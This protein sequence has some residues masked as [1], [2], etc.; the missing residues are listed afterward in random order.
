MW[1]KILKEQI[2]RSEFG[3]TNKQT[4]KALWTERR[5]SGRAASSSLL[6]A[7]PDHPAPKC[8][9][10]VFLAFPLRFSG[11]YQAVLK[12]NGPSSL[13]FSFFPP[14]PPHLCGLFLSHTQTEIPTAFSLPI[15]L[16][17][18]IW[19]GSLVSEAI[20]TF[21]YVSLHPGSSLTRHPHSFSKVFLFSE[22]ETPWDRARRAGRQTERGVFF[23]PTIFL[24]SPP[25]WS[26]S[27]FNTGAS[28]VP[29]RASSQHLSSEWWT[30]FR[31]SRQF[32]IFIAFAGSLWNFAYQIWEQ[33][34]PGWYLSTGSKS[35]IDSHHGCKCSLEQS[36]MVPSLKGESEFYMSRLPDCRF[37]WIPF[38][39]SPPLSCALRRHIHAHV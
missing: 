11:T 22:M 5:F 27:D 19:R 12:M 3:K 8:I 2:D 20:D 9:Q 1:K 13:P 6:P 26:L 34:L 16:H 23:S 18:L 15:Y 28:E 10:T 38:P 24:F 30:G 7:L 14:P 4:K 36:R 31:L 17:F 37:Y 32:A 39:C 25:S 33:Y 35:A 29:R 21:R